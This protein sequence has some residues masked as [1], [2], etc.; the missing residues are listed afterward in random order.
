LSRLHQIPRVLGQVTVNM[1]QGMKDHL[2][3]PRYLLEV[4][5]KHWSRDKMVDYFHRYTAMDGPNIQSE[6][7]RYIAWAG[8][9]LAYKIGQLEIPKLRE[10]ARAREQIWP[11]GLPR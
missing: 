6:V 2:M 4:H 7:D 1:R 8:Q 9:A 5:E 11:A 3:P 10:E